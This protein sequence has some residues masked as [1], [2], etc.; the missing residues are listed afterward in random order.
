M[1]GFSTGNATSGSV[2]TGALTS[3]ANYQISCTGSGGTAN[4]PIATVSVLSPTATITAT[5]V[6]V[7]SGNTSTI[8]WNAS[9]VTSCAVSGPGLSSTSLSGSQSLTITTQSTYTITCQT[10]GAPVTQSATVNVVPTFQQ[11]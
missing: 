8:A 2:S 6:Q 7:R 1:G 9:Q 4:S 10:L 3:S 11:F 5:P